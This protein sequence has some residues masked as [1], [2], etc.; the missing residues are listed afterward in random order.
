MPFWKKEGDE[1]KLFPHQIE[2]LE[3]VEGFQNAAFYLDM[4]M[5]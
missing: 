4:G 3:S 1:M 5:G 2:A